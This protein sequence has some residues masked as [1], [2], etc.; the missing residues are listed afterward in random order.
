MDV[1]L[2]SSSKRLTTIILTCQ[3]QSS[4]HH[5]GLQNPCEE[6]YNIYFLISGFF[7]GGVGVYFIAE[8][9]RVQA[10]FGAGDF[11]GH[12]IIKIGHNLIFATTFQTTRVRTEVEGGAS[13]GRPEKLRTRTFAALPTK[14]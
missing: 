8:Q 12:L 11:C 1:T 13:P 6:L 10:V 2:K 14:S 7:V 4:R 3:L 5:P 9:A